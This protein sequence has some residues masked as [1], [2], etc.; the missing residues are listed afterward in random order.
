ML[1]FVSHL[2]HL[3]TTAYLSHHI[4]LSHGGLFWRGLWVWRGGET[5]EVRSAWYGGDFWVFLGMFSGFMGMRRC[6]MVVCGGV[7]MGF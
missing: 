2:I 7:F 4:S 1:L 5:R 6:G 3:S